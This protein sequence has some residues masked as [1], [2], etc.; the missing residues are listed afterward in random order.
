MELRHLRY[1]VAVA[2]ELNF[3]RAAE[4]L[5][6]SQP[7]LS[8]QIRDLEQCVGVSLLERDKRTVTLTAAGES[9]LADALAILDQA[10]QA[11]IRARSAAIQNNHLV[12]GFVP[13]A[14][15]NLLPMVMPLLRL[16]QPETHIEL[17][18]LITT[19]QEEK[20]LS[21]ELD[22]GLMRHPVYSPKIESLALFHEPLVVV[23][24][25]THPLARERE[26]TA[27]QLNGV[28]FVSTDPAYSGE[29]AA[30]VD[31]WVTEQRCQLNV[32]QM[33]TNILVTMNMV[34]MGFGVSL[35]PGYMQSFNTGQVVFRPLAGEVPTIALLMVWKKGE[36]KPALRDFIDIVKTRCER[37]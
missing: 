5:H 14:E 33:A 23:M 35:I 32:V 28:N 17:V 6:T 25:A 34:G 31:K 3:T 27:E 12:I 22:V 24:P 1:F 13:S 2:Q 11:K 16:R 19:Q 20:L 18:S 10:E 9:F 29:L 30:I 26:I 15:V 4:K 21:G 7:S 36:L 37:L 8:S